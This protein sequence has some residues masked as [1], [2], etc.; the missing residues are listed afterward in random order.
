MTIE[1]NIY[2]IVMHSYETQYP[3]SFI[4]TTGN[5]ISKSHRT[6][7]LKIEMECAIVREW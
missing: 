3:N 4:K 1:N 2:N 5:T 6:E 7:E